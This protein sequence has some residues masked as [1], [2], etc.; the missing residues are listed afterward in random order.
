[1][2]SAK[3]TYLIQ[4]LERGIIG[5]KTAC[6]CRPKKDTRKFISRSFNNNRFKFDILEIYGTKIFETIFKEYDVIAIDE[7]QFYTSEEIEKIIELSIKYYYKDIYIASLNASSEQ[8]TFFNTVKIIPF[9]SKIIY[10]TAVCNICGNDEAFYTISKKPKSKQIKVGDSEYMV[11]C[12]KCY[13]HKYPNL[14][15]KEAIEIIE[16]IRNIYKKQ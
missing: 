2:F 12:A 14:P 6:F 13:A 3:S 15:F 16:K 1:M 7:L 11:L 10:L 4:K 5:G 8:Q 9:A